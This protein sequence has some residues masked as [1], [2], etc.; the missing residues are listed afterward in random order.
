[1]DKFIHFK[2]EIHKIKNFLDSPKEEEINIIDLKNSD[3]NRSV[4]IK[5]EIMQTESLKTNKKL[6]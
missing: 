3:V 2:S 6:K 4:L 5:S 1:M